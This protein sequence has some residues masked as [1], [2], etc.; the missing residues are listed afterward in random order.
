VAVDYCL[1]LLVHVEVSVSHDSIHRVPVTRGED[2]SQREL[3][4]R[5]SDEAIMNRLSNTWKTVRYRVVRSA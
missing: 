3:G 1:T 2:P 4:L 5:A